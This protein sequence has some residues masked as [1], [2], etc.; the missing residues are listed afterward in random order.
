MK[1]PYYQLR[2]KY[3]HF[4][5]ILNPVLLLIF[6]NDTLKRFMVNTHFLFY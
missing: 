2:H 1:V 6:L 3:A 5:C 4:S